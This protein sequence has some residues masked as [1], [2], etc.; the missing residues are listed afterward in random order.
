MPAA[1]TT[2]A[3]RK[4]RLRRRPRRATK[5]VHGTNS[6]VATPAAACSQSTALALW[7]ESSKAS[8]P[9]A[10]ASPRSKNREALVR[11]PGRP[12]SA[13]SLHCGRAARGYLEVRPHPAGLIAADQRRD[14]VAAGGGRR[15][16]EGRRLA[17]RQ[18]VR[19]VGRRPAGLDG[20]RIALALD[21][22]TRVGHRRP[23]LALHGDVPPGRDADHERAVA[24]AVVVELII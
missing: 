10:N 1:S 16:L 21:D 11:R 15:E 12:M 2:D 9:V 7:P 4:D 22:R 18:A 19:R 6:T 17:R 23:V 14:P 20:I 24:V 3:E 13:F 5:D 8:Q